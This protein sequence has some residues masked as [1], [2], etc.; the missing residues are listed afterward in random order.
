MR[1][2]DIDRTSTRQRL[3]RAMTICAAAA[4]GCVTEVAD[5]GAMRIRLDLP[6][7]AAR[8][9]VLGTGASLD[10]AP[11]PFRG[12]RR[13]AALGVVL[14]DTDGL[15]LV[16]IA[17]DTIRALEETPVPK[18]FRDGATALSDGVLLTGV[19]EETELGLQNLIERNGSG[20]VQIYS[21][22]GVLG[23][24][25][26]R[27][28]YEEGGFGD[29]LDL[30]PIG[31]GQFFELGPGVRAVALALSGPNGEPAAG[32]RLEGRSNVVAYLPRLGAGETH[33]PL[34]VETLDRSRTVFVDAD[35]PSVELLEI[36]AAEHRRGIEVR[37][38]R[39]TRTAIDPMRIAPLTNRGLKLASDGAEY[40]F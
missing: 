22:P 7:G 10:P 1:Q 33:A 16:D 30:H 34:V 15:Y 14:P 17:A 6:P 24:L 13:R 2:K 31:S 40:W 38:T 8:V 5:E 27:P 11:D 18:G 26:D 36:L 4:T 23:R 21:T 37:L 39:L 35:A 25:Q 12:E 32:W 9:V 19:D 28:S 3:L 20:K 29:R